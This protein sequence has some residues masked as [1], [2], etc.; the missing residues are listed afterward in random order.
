MSGLRISIRSIVATMCCA[1]F[2]EAVTRAL[3]CEA[4]HVS[5]HRERGAGRG[6][7][8]SRDQGQQQGPQ[9]QRQRTDAGVA[10]FDGQ[11]QRFP[12][13]IDVIQGHSAPVAAQQGYQQGSQQGQQQQ[14]SLSSIL[15]NQRDSSRFFSK[16]SFH[17]KNNSTRFFSKNSFHIKNN[18][19]RFFSKNALQSKR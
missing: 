18:S 17:I 12:R 13:E 16:N 5:Y 3:Q 2:S 4:A 1:T 9:A 7:G 8:R 19:T 14:N 6:R 15:F 10:A 11:I